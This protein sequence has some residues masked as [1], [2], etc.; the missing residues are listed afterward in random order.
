MS[1]SARGS[2][3]I[4]GSDIHLRQTTSKDRHRPVVFNVTY[5]MSR[6][7]VEPDWDPLI[8][9]HVSRV[10]RESDGQRAKSRVYAFVDMRVVLAVFLSYNMMRRGEHSQRGR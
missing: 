9:R 6:I 1:A 4:E 7:A 2:S 8:L 5:I 3:F 10:M